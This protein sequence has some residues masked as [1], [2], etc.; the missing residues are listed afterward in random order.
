MED[1]AW[2]TKVTTFLVVM[3]CKEGILAGGSG[4]AKCYLLE[5]IL[6]WRSRKAAVAAFFPHSP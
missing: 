3:N 4:G 5:W 2:S 6:F 1:Y